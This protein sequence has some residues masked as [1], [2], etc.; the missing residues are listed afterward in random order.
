MKYLIA[1]LMLL[2]LNSCTN[3]LIEEPNDLL[4]SWQEQSMHHH[5]IIFND[6]NTIDGMWWENA[7]YSYKNSNVTIIYDYMTEQNI[8]MSTV[9]WVCQ[10][11]INNDTLQL[12]TIS[13]EYKIGDN[14]TWV[15][16]QGS[17]GITLYYIRK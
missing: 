5:T 15:E 1:L 17:S 14:S 10:Y 11:N 16:E 8:K 3:A 2:V 7:K 9:K 12:T 4:G 6:D 13:Y